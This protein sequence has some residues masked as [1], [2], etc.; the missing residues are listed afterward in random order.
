[1]LR[2]GRVQLSGEGAAAREGCECCNG[3]NTT[4]GAILHWVPCCDGCNTAGRG[5]VLQDRVQHPLRGARPHCHSPAGEEVTGQGQVRSVL[6][7]G[8]ELAGGVC[9]EKGE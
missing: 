1:M 4:V 5:A 7:G 8:A 9:G 6:E 3:Y 2:E